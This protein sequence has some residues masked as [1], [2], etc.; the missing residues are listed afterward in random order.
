[1]IR[2]I[3]RISTKLHFKPNLTP[4]LYR[5]LH[6]SS[7]TPSSTRA[8]TAIHPPAPKISA[9]NDAARYS[10]VPAGQNPKFLSYLRPNDLLCFILLSMMTSPSILKW[11]IKLMP[12]V[13]NFLV[14]QFVYPIYCGG[15]N[16]SELRATGDKLLQRGY[17][18][19]MLSYSVEDAEGTKGGLVDQ[20]IPQT[21]GSVDEVLVKTYEKNAELYEKG[22]TTVPPTSGYVAIKPTGLLSQA[23]DILKN[24]DQPEYAEKWQAYLDVCRTICRHADVYGKGKVVIIFDAEK[25]V[26]QRGV[27]EAQ[28]VMMREFNRNGKIV[29]AGT[30]QMYLQD[31][32]D[33]L[34]LE[35]DLA[36]KD[37]YQIALKL[38]RGAYIHSEPDRWN[39]IHKTKEDTDV[40][41]D[42]GIAMMVDSIVEGW[43]N[44][45]VGPIDGVRP[46][47]GRVIVASHNEK[48]AGI[49]DERIRNEA[50][51]G[52]DLAKD[53][54]IVFGQLLG[55]AEDAGQELANRGHKV[56]KYVPWG[57][58]QETKDYLVRRLEENGDAVREGGWQYVKYGVAEAFRRVLGRA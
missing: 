40:S 44:P 31:S 7:T 54:S 43:N 3:P 58:T 37:N 56:I 22:L 51:L 25:K 18:N 23:T 14:K 38:V 20:V 5:A 55:M 21:L 15:E 8:E 52:V 48:S 41:Y 30:I 17:G 6:Q 47:V 10:L 26:L 34:K 19:M 29:V 11:S 28:R 46:V 49:V 12:I 35:M 32:V 33:Q 39:T 4:V 24:F 16:F 2:T 13:P 57:P 9:E 1:M 45:S 42:T 27:Y 50:P 36:K 53:E